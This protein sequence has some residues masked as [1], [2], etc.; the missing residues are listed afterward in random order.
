MAPTPLF[1]AL[2][3]ALLAGAASAKD[4]PVNLKPGEVV[5]SGAVGLFAMGQRL[6]VLGLQAKD[7]VAVLTAAK[8]VGSVQFVETERKK[9]TK[10]PERA[11]AEDLHKGPAGVASM[12]AAARELAGEDET[13]IGVVEAVE[14]DMGHGRMISVATS[15]TTLT[16]GKTDRWEVPLFGETAVELAVVGDGDAPLSVLVADENG[17][18]ICQDPGGSAVA[19][20]AFTP[21]TN[22]TFVVT[23]SN[24]GKAP[25]SYILMTN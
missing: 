21:A 17:H 12:L 23:V 15:R 10:G 6:Y 20:C 11:P 24:L 18:V 3:L 16:A 14:R 22:A 4:K 25:D 19:Y 2:A 7:P 13:L 8:L 5:T 9:E 1:L